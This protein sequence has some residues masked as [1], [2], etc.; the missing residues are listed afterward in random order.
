MIYTSELNLPTGAKTKER[1]F[2]AGSMGPDENG[3]T[4]RDRFSE[5]LKDVYDFLD[6]TCHNHDSLNEEGMKN[7]I[8]WELNAMELADVIVLRFLPDA[9][10][11][12]S[13]VELGLYTFTNKLIV[14][15]PKEFYKYRYV[16]VLCEKYK[17]PFFSNLEDV[18]TFLNIRKTID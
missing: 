13:L 4:W 6:P 16:R 1:I 9:E 18:I 15:C 17:T 3:I 11:P 12:I 2:L 14:V 5:E 8:L 7:H 10:S